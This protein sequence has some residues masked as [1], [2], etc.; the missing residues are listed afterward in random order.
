MKPIIDVAVKKAPNAQCAGRITISWSG[1]AARI[2]NGAQ[3]RAEG[4]EPAHDQRVDQDQHDAKGGTQIAEDLVGDVPFAVAFH[5]RRSVENGWR[6]FQIASG[7]SRSLGYHAS[8][9]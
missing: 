5:A 3:R 4:A 2:I 6:M 8:P 7:A 1:M 9:A